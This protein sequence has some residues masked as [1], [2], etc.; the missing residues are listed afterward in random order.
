[1]ISEEIELNDFLEKNG[2]VPVETDLGEYIIQLR[3]EHPSHIIAPAVHLNK[4]QVEADFRRVHTHLDPKRDLTEPTTSW[5]RRAASFGPSSWPPTSGSPGEL[6]GG[7]DRDVDLVTNEGNG[8]L[9]QILP[10]VHIVIASI[11]KVTPTPVGRG[12]DPARARALGDRP[13]MSVYTTLSTG[14]APSRGSR[15]A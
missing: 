6:P 3:G 4:D 8:D 13:G 2:V 10:K 15:R 9:T 12:A 11:E 14:P 1:M 5:P 7:G